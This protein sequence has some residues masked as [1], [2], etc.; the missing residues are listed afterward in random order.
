MD[1][2]ECP[3]K[4]TNQ[5]ERQPMTKQEFKRRW[6]SGPDGDGLNYDDIADC[7][8]E[9]RLC[10]TPR[11]RPIYQIRYAVLKAAGVED[12]EEYNPDTWAEGVRNS[13]PSPR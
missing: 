9:W 12:A 5:E 7:A 6:E 2:S 10:A 3:A 13:L 4:A 8:K 1:W 11:I